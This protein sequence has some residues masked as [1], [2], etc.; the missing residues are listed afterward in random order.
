MENPPAEIELPV[1]AAIVGQGAAA[2]LVSFFRIFR[3]MPNIEGILLNPA[4]APV[5]DDPA[6]LYALSAALARRATDGNFDRIYAYAKR[7]PGEFTVYCIQ[8]ATNRDRKL[9]HTQAFSD[10]CI[11]HGNLFLS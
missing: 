1:Y 11:T 7:M 5:P 10:F 6:T 4:T 3:Q 2:E 8:D 9:E